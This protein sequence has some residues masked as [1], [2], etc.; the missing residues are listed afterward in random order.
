MRAFTVAFLAVIA[1]CSK[2][3][4]QPDTT[5]TL[6]PVATA[7]APSGQ[8]TLDDFRRLRWLQLL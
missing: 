7:I 6:P 5:S 4:P 1:A 8:F 3:V 2:D